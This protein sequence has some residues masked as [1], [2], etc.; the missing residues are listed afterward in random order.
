MRNVM[1]IDDIEISG[2]AILADGTEQ[3]I[4]DVD[5]GALI[6]EELSRNTDTTSVNAFLTT[7]TL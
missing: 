3:D 6:M 5:F 2:V 1:V 4:R 7:C